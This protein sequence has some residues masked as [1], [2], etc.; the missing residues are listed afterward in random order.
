LREIGNFDFVMVKQNDDVPPVELF[1]ERL[2]TKLKSD[3]KIGLRLEVTKTYPI[4]DAPKPSAT[5]RIH[6]DC[7]EYSSKDKQQKMF[8]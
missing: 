1:I 3:I 7:D 8:G 2:E 5:G 4:V 6:E